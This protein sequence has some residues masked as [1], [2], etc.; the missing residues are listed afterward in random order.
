MNPFDHASSFVAEMPSEHV[1][2]RML[3]ASHP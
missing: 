1:I 2:E 3:T